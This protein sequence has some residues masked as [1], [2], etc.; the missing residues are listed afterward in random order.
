M[1]AAVVPLIE[2]RAVLYRETVSGTYSRLSY[3]IGSL[4]ADVPFHILN[5]CLMFI[6][7][8]F[9]VGFS[10]DG[11]IAGYFILMLFLANWVIMS[12]GQ[13]YALVSP[14]EESAH[15]L[16][17][18]SVILSVILMGF[19]ITVSAMPKGWTWA[20]WANLFHYIL[21]GLVSNELVGKVYHLDLDLSGIVPTNMTDAATNI[22]LFQPGIDGLRDD[23]ATEVGTLLSIIASTGNGTNPNSALGD[24]VGL[25]T[26]FGDNN[27]MTNV[28]S[29]LMSCV[30]FRCREE[31]SDAVASFPLEEVTSCFGPDFGENATLDS[32]ELVRGAP[33]D[34]SIE[35][36]DGL[37][38]AQQWS[39]LLCLIRA[40]L[41]PQLEEII[42]G[43][44]GFIKD[45]FNLIL[46]V[47]DVIENGINL[48][49]E[50][51]LFFFGWA[52]FEDGSFSGDFKWHYCLTSVAVFLVCIEIF[53]LIAVRFIVWTKR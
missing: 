24:I 4:I 10:L 44:I 49:G 50:L 20:Y 29:S 41:P 40:F 3:G 51:I 39:V 22:V 33:S 37:G 15:G 43:I 34:F 28:P 7:F 45:N 38:K 21:Q 11:P 47:V 12:M 25:L 32:S 46:I 6:F 26:C 27:C 16:A 53:K 42:S 31:F 48:P 36:Y 23:N 19:L 30:A 8:Y 9:L 35:A 52:T 1:A 5:T 13:L 2:D 17:G 14:N 18:L